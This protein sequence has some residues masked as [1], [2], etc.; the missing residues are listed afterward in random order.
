MK[1]AVIIGAGPSGLAAAYEL[2]K[3]NDM[4]VIIL[5]AGDRAGGTARTYEFEENFVDVGPH[6]Y[7]THS[8][9]VQSIWDQ[10]LPEQGAPSRDDI[11]LGRAVELNPDGS[12]PERQDPVMLKRPRVSRILYDNKF[13]N[14]PLNFNMDTIR[15][16]GLKKTFY[17]GF[18]LLK[19]RLFRRKEHSL[20]DYM[21]N[22]FGMGLYN[23]F[24]R[25]YTYKA[26]GDDPESISSKC[27]TQRIQG[28]SIRKAVKQLIK[29]VLK[30]KP[31]EKD[32]LKGSINE[33]KELRYP[34]YGAGQ[35]WNRIAEHIE[36]GGIPI[37][38]HSRVS[39]IKIQNRK[40]TGI[41]IETA[42]GPIKMEADY[43]ISSMPLADLFTC[44]TPDIKTKEEEAV[45]QSAMALR[46]RNFVMVGIFASRLKMKNDTGNKTVNGILPDCWSYIY[47]NVAKMSRFNI[48]NN[49]SPYVVRNWDSEVF[50]GME[51]LCDERDEIWTL[52][53]G[54]SVNMAVA[55]GEKLNLLQKEDIIRTVRVKEPQAYPVYSG[56]YE[57]I[58][59][60]ISYINSIE[61]LYSVGRKGQHRYLDMDQSM[62]TAIECVKHI[63][64]EIP[65]K[66][67]IWEVTE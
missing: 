53:E 31:G 65:D 19:A 60:I 29:S 40:V 12:D 41:T 63:Y 6:H 21:I 17:F 61:N 35:M 4:E 49:F 58:D 30:M 56:S 67:S 9:Y 23:E 24:F 26:W 13:F 43:V 44:L 62:L 52:D 48:Y 33:V 3:R 39:Q 36:A 2:L 37:R 27:G 51:Y 38:Y 66:N 57:D 20:E 16:L 32:S 50:I 14:Y 34:K 55:E 5:E 15:K 1:K 25:T 28:I 45:Y 18:G 7:F 10:F 42:E 59:R 22:N 11:L 64:H 8:R 54:H 46:Y 47:N